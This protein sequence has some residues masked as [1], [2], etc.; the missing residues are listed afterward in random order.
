MALE[1]E[2]GLGALCSEMF[3]PTWAWMN[4]QK[5]LLLPHT[6]QCPAD[7]SEERDP[8]GWCSVSVG[9]SVVLT[10][11]L[12]IPTLMTLKGPPH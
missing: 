9:R 10:G 8:T 5:A 4:S 6:A 2:T 1:A 7:V 11:L 3:A 12:V